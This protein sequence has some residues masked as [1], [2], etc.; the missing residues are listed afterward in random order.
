MK[1]FYKKRAFPDVTLTFAC[2]W[3]CGS[4][5]FFVMQRRMQILKKTKKYSTSLYVVITTLLDKMV[6]E[7]LCWFSDNDDKS[8]KILIKLLLLKVFITF[9]CAA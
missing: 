1:T 5:M 2:L 4:I 8:L 3:I 7:R 9:C 6:P